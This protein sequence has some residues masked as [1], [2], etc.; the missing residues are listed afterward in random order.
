M[1]LYQ[2]EYRVTTPGRVRKV[3]ET[4]RAPTDAAADTKAHDDFLDGDD[5]YTNAFLFHIGDEITLT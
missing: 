1:R 5:P 2:L 3:K 4:F